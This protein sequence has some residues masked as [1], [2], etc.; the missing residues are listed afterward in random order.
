[1]KYYVDFFLLPDPEFP[2]SFLINVL[3]AKL[4][5]VFVEIDNREL[6]VSKRRSPSKVV[7]EAA[8]R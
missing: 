4:H 3:F 1:M 6:G 2:S 7:Y 5:R 8:C